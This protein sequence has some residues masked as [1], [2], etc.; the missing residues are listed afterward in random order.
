[1]SC[2]L[3]LYMSEGI[4]SLKSTSNDWFMKNISWQF[5]LLSEFLPEIH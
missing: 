1:M 5:Y 2:E 3:I 4:Y